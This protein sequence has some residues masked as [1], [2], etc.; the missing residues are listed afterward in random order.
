M[1]LIAQMLLTAFTDVVTALLESPA[2]AERVY[3][4]SASSALKSCFRLEDESTPAFEATSYFPACTTVPTVHLARS[5]LPAPT[6]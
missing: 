3:T 2:L 4:P 1:R 5:S 6:P